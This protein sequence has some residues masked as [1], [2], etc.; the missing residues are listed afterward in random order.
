MCIA[1]VVDCSG[2]SV[3]GIT[4]SRK[5]T[6]RERSVLVDAAQPTTINNPKAEQVCEAL[7]GARD[8]PLLTSS[9]SPSSELRPVNITTKDQRRTNAQISKWRAYIAWVETEFSLE[10]GHPA[11]VG[12]WV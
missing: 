6:S 5:E 9:S 3:L 12:I 4:A 11:Q 8:L 1:S 2:V 7:T 10:L